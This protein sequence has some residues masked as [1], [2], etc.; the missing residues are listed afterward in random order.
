MFSNS[1]FKTFNMHKTG[2][3]ER[4]FGGGGVRVSSSDGYLHSCLTRLLVLPFSKGL[5]R[6]SYCKLS[7]HPHPGVHKIQVSNRSGEFCMA[8]PNIWLCPSCQIEFG[9]GWRI[10]LL[11]FIRHHNGKFRIKVSV[12]CVPWIVGTCCG[13]RNGLQYGRQ[14]RIHWISGRVKPTRGG[15]LAWGLGEVLTT[16]HRKNSPCYETDTCA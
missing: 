1:V 9:C 7:T 14:L 6:V 10:I 8:A 2:G 15:P 16:P 12:V 4:G 11:Q 3:R 5:P 13:C